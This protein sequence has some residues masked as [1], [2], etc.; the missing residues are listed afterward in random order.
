[1]DRVSSP[2]VPRDPAVVLDAENAGLGALAELV[3]AGGVAVLSGAGLS[4]ESGIPDYRGPTGRARPSTPMTY[5]TFT[6]SAAARQ[7]YWARSSL[8]W[9]RIGDARPNS[10][11]HCVTRL[12]TAGL[13]DGI[14]TQNV[15]GLHSAAGAHDVIELHGNL[16]RVVCLGCG[17]VT[18]RRRLAERLDAANADWGAEVRAVNPDGDVDIDDSA[19]DGFTVVECETCG[20]VLKPDVVFFGERVPLDR[21]HRSR[22]LVGAA[23]T[24]LVLGS[25]L[26]V[27]SGFRF[28]LQAAK[29][30]TPV[31]IVTDGE[32]RADAYAAVKIE[33]PLGVVL[34]GLVDRLLGRTGLRR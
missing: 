26:T 16:S 34:P 21:V 22:A 15:D 3:G 8:G 11:H 12:Q 28:V 29:Q 14:V 9:T 2:L 25:S 33:A 23:R 27:M 32:T 10:G 1:M 17:E 24:L 31:A 6:G 5:Q 20:G 18:D 13:V 7:R 19:L 4:T 30:G